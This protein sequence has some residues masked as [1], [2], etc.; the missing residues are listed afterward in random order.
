MN[1]N[2]ILT[3]TILTLCVSAWL[4]LQPAFAQ[5]AKARKAMTPEQIEAFLK[6][7]Q[8]KDWQ[9]T[10]KTKTETFSGKINDVWAGERVSVVALHCDRVQ[11]L[12]GRGGSSQL[13]QIHFPYFARRERD[14]RKWDGI[15]RDSGR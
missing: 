10:V 8:K 7:A 12:S 11:A 9:V 5:I 6:E 13:A 14:G 3:K 4:M 1:F 2:S 15:V